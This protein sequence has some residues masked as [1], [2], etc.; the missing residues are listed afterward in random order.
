M[1][2]FLLTKECNDNNYFQALDQNKWCEGNFAVLGIG[3]WHISEKNPEF[4]LKWP[5]FKSY[6]HPSLACEILSKG[7]TMRLSV[8]SSVKCKQKEIFHRAAAMKRHHVYEGTLKTIRNIPIICHHYQSVWMSY[9]DSFSLSYL[10]FMKDS[11]LSCQLCLHSVTIKH[12]IL[13]D[14]LIGFKWLKEWPQPHISS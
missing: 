1:T 11:L 7:Y 12:F 9:F 10:V 4:V 6:L 8:L 2:I 14:N 3:C 13:H 5:E